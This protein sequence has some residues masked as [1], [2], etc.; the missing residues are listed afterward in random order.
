VVLAFELLAVSGMKTG[1]G[2]VDKVASASVAF[3]FFAFSGVE[4][5]V[6]KGADC[7]LIFCFEE[8]TWGAGGFAHFLSKKSKKLKKCDTLTVTPVTT[9]RLCQC[10]W[11]D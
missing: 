5:A 9:H 10:V 4:T 3:G 8:R 2:G 7:W 11:C 1:G 6:A